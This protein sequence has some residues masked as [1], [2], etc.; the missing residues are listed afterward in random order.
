MPRPLRTNPAF[1]HLAYRKTIIT[2][3]LTF[4][5]R[6]YLG[7]E[8]SEP[9]ETLICEEVFPTD[10]HVPQEEI[11]HYM[12]SLTDEAAQ[13]EVELSRFR[14]VQPIEQGHNGQ[15]QQKHKKGSGQH[16]QKGSPSNGKVSRAH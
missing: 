14:L 1:A 10:S 8:I 16:Q 5:R 15:R 3:T 4:L 2:R 12:E 7:D 13:I 6:T 11:Q 9:K